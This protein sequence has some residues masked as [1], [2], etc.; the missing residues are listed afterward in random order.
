MWKVDVLIHEVEYDF[1]DVDDYGDPIRGLTPRCPMELTVNANVDA[2]TKWNLMGFIEGELCR[3][4]PT[5]SVYEI[6][7]EILVVRASPT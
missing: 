4:F 2:P 1:E 7:F 3:R 5:I 6:D